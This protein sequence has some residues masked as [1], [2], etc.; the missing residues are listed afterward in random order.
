MAWFSKAIGEGLAECAVV[1]GSLEHV[2]VKI[3]RT[4]LSPEQAE[5]VAAALIKAA[6][7]A[8]ENRLRSFVASQR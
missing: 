4:G 7:V 2:Y 5:E 6:E 3:T 1:T 8:R